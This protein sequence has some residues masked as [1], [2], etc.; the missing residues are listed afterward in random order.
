MAV[1]HEGVPESVQA[2]GMG[3]VRV[4]VLTSVVRRIVRPVTSPIV[5]AVTGPIVRPVVGT[6]VLT[7]PVLG[8]H[9]VSIPDVCPPDP[10]TSAW[11]TTEL[12]M[13]RVER[14]T[15]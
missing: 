1:R 2:S 4:P 9:D 6:A 8:T 14:P 15:A 5:M 11:L 10:V 12:G 13:A 7:R 3:V